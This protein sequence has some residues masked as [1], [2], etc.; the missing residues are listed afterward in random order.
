[1]EGW[2]KD[3]LEFDIAAW[4]GSVFVIVLSLHGRRDAEKVLRTIR[5]HIASCPTEEV[6]FH[7]GGI[8]FVTLKPPEKPPGGGYISI[9]GAFC[10]TPPVVLAAA[11][12]R[13]LDN[14]S[15]TFY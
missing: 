7:V 15:Q 10:G 8:A 4:P 12:R 2:L 9:M 3:Q 14:K 13:A 1:E 6:K 5:A 11:V